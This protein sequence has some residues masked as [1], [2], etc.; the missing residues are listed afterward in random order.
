[1]ASFCNLPQSISFKYESQS[2]VGNLKMEIILLEK[3]LCLREGL[4]SGV[5]GGNPVV[6]VTNI[7]GRTFKLAKH[8]WP[9]GQLM[10]LLHL[11]QAFCVAGISPLCWS[12]TPPV[13][14]LMQKWSYY[15]SAR[16]LGLP[17]TIG[18]D[19]GGKAETGDGDHVTLDW[20]C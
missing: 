12:R 14:M 1:M 8:V 7:K 16:I 5:D 18:R 3:C 20:S 10:K 15:T 2:L 13:F 6:G 9:T 19:A 11:P 17:E 4:C